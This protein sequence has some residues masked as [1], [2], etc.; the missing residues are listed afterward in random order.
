MKRRNP[1]APQ[2]CHCGD[3]FSDYQKGEIRTAVCRDLPVKYIHD[4]KLYCVFHFPSE[5]KKDEFALELNTKIQQEDYL[6]YGTWMPSEIDFSG[7]V[8]NKWA[9]FEW[10][11]FN[12]EATFKE[13]Q[14]K[15][16]CQ[17]LCASFKSAV[18]FNGAV[19][20]KSENDYSPTNF[21]AAIFEGALDFN[22]SK[23]KRKVDFTE[24]TFL[25]GY[26]ST[27]NE[28]PSPSYSSFSNATFEDEAHFEATT[29]GNLKQ[30]ENFDSF[31]FNETI[32][33]KLAN[34]QNVI[35][36]LQTDFSRA[37]FKRTADFRNT[38][39]RT[40]LSFSG[41]SFEGFAKFSGK[42]N[43]HNSWP[44]GSLDFTSV[45]IEKA[46]KISFQVVGLS[47]DS[48]ISTDVRK[49][50]FTDVKWKLKSFAFDWSRFKDTL[51]HKFAAQRR[52]SDYERLE[53][54]YRRLAANAEDNAHYRH[55]SK[56]RYT[57]FEIQR[58][59]R[60]YGR[61]PITLL[62]WYKWTSR[63]GENWGWAT[64]ILLA[65]L[66]ASAFLY[67]KVGFYVCPMDR[68]VSLSSSAGLCEIRP[69][70]L[71]EA[72]R[73]SLATATFQNIEFRRPASGIA[74]TL[75]LIEKILAPIQAALI[76]LAIRRKFMR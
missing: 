29:F 60:W 59:N 50:D 19:F 75:V 41:A 14:F 55:A 10:V 12:H 74:E 64:L 37:V 8:F 68:P 4:D 53:V 11:T 34:F 43:N 2:V 5:E 15:A 40:R 21:H 71:D 20:G 6:F 7:H 73:H 33:E 44:K 9:N 52:Q 62:W 48:F 13:A 67:T 69:L 51:F 31:L 36:I 72:S 54:A 22:S 42:G 58:I 32:F 47:P 26:S 56:F 46:E 65:I 30:L 1:T 66:G 38:Y 35:F 23:F 27:V 28:Y 45:E 16:N 76:A 49:F 70:D 24:C 57:A 3:H 25:V 18:S 63:Y 39:I 17:F 61:L